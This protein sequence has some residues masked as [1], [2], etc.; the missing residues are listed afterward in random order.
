MEQSKNAFKINQKLK[1]ETSCKKTMFISSL[2]FAFTA[3]LAMAVYFFVPAYYRV[4]TVSAEV[5]SE[6]QEFSL[7]YTV[8]LEK[9]PEEDFIVLN[10]ADVQII[11]YDLLD[12]DYQKAIDLITQLIE[13]TQPDLITLTGDNCAGYKND[14]VVKKFIK[15]IDS[16]D[17]PW[18]PVMGNH[19]ND[20]SGD[21]N[22]VADLMMNAENYVMKKGP[23]EMGVGNYV[24]T[25]IENDTIVQALIMMDSHDNEVWDNQQDWYSWVVNGLR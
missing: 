15:F 19:D 6:T 21:Y 16:F 20:G 12:G 25:I 9:D 11:D 4:G 13:E 2:F 10:L 23:S 3:V 22:W 18:A 7:D 1:D 8:Q 14:L 24:I 17:I 5:W